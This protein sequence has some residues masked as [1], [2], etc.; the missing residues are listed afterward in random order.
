MFCLLGGCQSEGKLANT[1]NGLGGALAPMSVDEYARQRGISPG[2]ARQEL[3]EKV[4]QR[5]ADEAIKK[6][7]EVGTSHE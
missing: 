3:Q 4:S 5:D 6:I 7:D 2:Q 1:K